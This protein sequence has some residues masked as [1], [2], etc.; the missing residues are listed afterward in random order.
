MV[1]DNVALITIEGL[2]L[3]IPDK[4]VSLKDLIDGMKDSI[5]K[6]CVADYPFWLVADKMEQ[7][8]LIMVTAVD[9]V[10]KQRGVTGL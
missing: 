1:S 9:V 2:R 7:E 10:R 3:H 6:V 5:K 4:W 8:R